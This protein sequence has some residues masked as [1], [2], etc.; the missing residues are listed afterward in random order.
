MPERLTKAASQS[1]L[2]PETYLSHRAAAGE[3]LRELKEAQSRHMSV[4]KKAKADG[5]DTKNMLMLMQLQKQEPDVVQATFRDLARFSAWEGRPLGTQAGLFGS[6]DSPVPTSAA[7]E[8]FREAEVKQ[9]GYTAG[10]HG[11][12]VEDCPGAYV[13]GSPHY[14]TWVAGHKLGCDFMKGMGKT[15][16]KAKTVAKGKKAGKGNP[17]DR[18]AS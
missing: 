6:D 17:E 15:P 13:P 9:E 1:N 18:I 4:L 5:V 7:S 8:A 2:T 11:T 3:S 12:P 10:L 16:G 14:V